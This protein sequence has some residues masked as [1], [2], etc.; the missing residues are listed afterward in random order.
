MRACHKFRPP[1]APALRFVNH[2]ALVLRFATTQ[3]Y[4]LADGGW[5]YLAGHTSTTG[6][7]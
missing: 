2:T 4:V 1:Q 3:T 5:S 6:V 7:G